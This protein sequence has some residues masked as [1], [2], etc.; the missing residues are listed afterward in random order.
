LR[1]RSFVAALATL[2]GWLGGCAALMPE[3]DEPEL[4]VGPPLARFSITGRLALRQ[5][6]RRDHLGF[7]WQHSPESDTVLLLSPLGQ[8]LA[9][10]LRDAGGAQL[11][12]PGEPMV[13]APTLAAL[14]QHVFGVNLP[15]QELGEW[16]RGAR[17]RDGQ[18][19]GWTIRV[20][21]TLAY[22]DAASPRRLPRRLLATRE[23]VELTLIV[24]DWSGN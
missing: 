11:K 2:P 22:P 10:I 5:G 21:Q 16:V 20:L 9:E 19:D 7:D 17:G 15:L 1:R 23:D 8:G 18:S 3:V 6:E 12:R 24:D 13:S 4:T 14:A